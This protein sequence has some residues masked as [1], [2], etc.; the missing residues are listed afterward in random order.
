[1]PIAYCELDIFLPYCQ[2]LKEKRM[3][4]R[5]TQDRLRSRFNF[6]VAEIAHQE[7]WQR[8]QI[9]AVT[10]GADRKLL[11]KLADQF[12]RESEEI[13]GESLVESRVEIID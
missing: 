13:L 9:G 11:E 8:S 10:V 6:S 7:L 4:L 5:K 2:S 3:I 12:V 1:M